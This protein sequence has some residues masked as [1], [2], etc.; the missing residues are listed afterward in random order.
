MEV[1][2]IYQLG[3]NFLNIVTKFKVKKYWCN[4]Q[5]KMIL[6]LCQQNFS[7]KQYNLLINLLILLA[8]GKN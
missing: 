1:V 8:I 2:Q 5:Y 3:N 7:K 4:I 6:F